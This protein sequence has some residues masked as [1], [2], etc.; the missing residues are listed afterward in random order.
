[1]AAVQKLFARKLQDGS[2]VAATL[3]YDRALGEATAEISVRS[4]HA[5]DDLATKLAIAIRKALD[6]RGAVPLEQE[7]V[8]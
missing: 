3:F 7:T 6:Q 8:E 2:E 1:M 4:A 5:A